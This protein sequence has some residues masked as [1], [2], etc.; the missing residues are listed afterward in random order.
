[1]NPQNALIGDESGIDLPQ[2]PVD[3]QALG[4][5]RN[6]AKYSRSKEYLELKAKAQVRIDFY[7]SFLPDGRPVATAS[8]AERADAWGFANLLIAEFQQLFGE[9]ENAE[10]ILKDEFGEQ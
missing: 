4:E 6:K 9:H 1:M 3:E 2:K 7:K 8:K 10:Q 5:L